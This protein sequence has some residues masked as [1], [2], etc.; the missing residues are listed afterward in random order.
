MLPKFNQKKSQ[1]ELN[2]HG[3]QVTE[4]IFPNGLLVSFFYQF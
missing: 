4:A 2:W 1:I 3:S